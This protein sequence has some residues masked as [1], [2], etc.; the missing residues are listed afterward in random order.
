MDYCVEV[1]N[2][3]HKKDIEKLEK[4]QNKMT[5]LLKHGSIMSHKERNETLKHT[6]HYERRQRGDMIYM[7]KNIHNP[8]YFTTRDDTNKGRGHS[9]YI[10]KRYIKTNIRK[11]SFSCRNVDAWNDLKK[12][13]CHIRRFKSFQK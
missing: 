13:C 10:I 1:W 9:M 6:T 2:P 3:C 7:Y 12:L 5:K 8:K 11:H 4:T